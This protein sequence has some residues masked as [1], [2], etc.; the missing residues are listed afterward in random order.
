MHF[1]ESYFLSISFNTGLET[2][3]S[4]CQ[5]SR[6]DRLQFLPVRRK[7]FSP[8]YKGKTENNEKMEQNKMPFSLIKD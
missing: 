2:N 4:A 1:I 5:S 7:L 3:F 8:P 6:T